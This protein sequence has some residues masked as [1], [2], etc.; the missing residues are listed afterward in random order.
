MDKQLHDFRTIP[1]LP[2]LLRNT[3]ILVSCAL[4]TMFVCAQ[5][6]VSKAPTHEAVSGFERP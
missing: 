2:P 5:L 1:P 4:V 6:Y 3:L